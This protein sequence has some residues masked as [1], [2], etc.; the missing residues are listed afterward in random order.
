MSSH[1]GIQDLLYGKDAIHKT[2][3]SVHKHTLY[4]VLTLQ[5][6][7]MIFNVVPWKTWKS[8]KFCF[9]GKVNSKQVIA[10]KS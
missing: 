1:K 3:Q 8:A 5:V 9:H 4:K 10:V 6:E 7:E 2:F